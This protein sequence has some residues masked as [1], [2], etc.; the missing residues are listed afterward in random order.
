MR[1]SAP[2]MDTG[3][4]DLATANVDL[5]VLYHRRSGIKL[6]DCQQNMM[7][8][9]EMTANVYIA[10]KYGIWTTKHH[11]CL[12][13]CLC[14]FMFLPH[15]ARDFCSVELI[16]RLYQDMPKGVVLAPLKVVNH[17]GVSFNPLMGHLGYIYIYISSL[18]LATKA[19]ITPK[20]AR[21]KCVSFACRKIQKSKFVLSSLPP[22]LPKMYINSVITKTIVF[23]CFD[24]SLIQYRY[25]R[26]V[27]VLFGMAVSL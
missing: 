27:L 15:F 3:D 8:H 25:L 16:I 9:G 17:Y 6:Q 22:S 4:G 10:F 1:G 23:R 19:L 26:F 14:F 2:T 21:V 24:P 18:F 13:R 20:T 5:T 12:G 7:D 11:S